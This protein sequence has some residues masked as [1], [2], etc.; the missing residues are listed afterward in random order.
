MYHDIVNVND[1]FV[2]VSTDS[3]YNVDDALYFQNPFPGCSYLDVH[4]ELH[5]RNVAYTLRHMKHSSSGLDN[6]PSWF[7][8][9]VRIRLLKLLL[10]SLTCLFITEQSHNSGKE[11]LLLLFLK[12]SNQTQYVTIAPSRLH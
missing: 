5:V 9:I 4:D 12:S 6:I 8:V 2:N 11:Q 1:Y 3:S 10:L 7:F